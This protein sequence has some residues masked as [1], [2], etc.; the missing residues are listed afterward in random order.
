LGSLNVQGIRNKTGEITKGLEELNQDITIL[1]GTK[2]KGNGVEILG[3]Y[4]HFYS[5]VSKEKRAKRGTSIL[6]KK[7]YER[8]I[9][10]WEAI[11]ENTIKL[12]MNVFGKKLC[13]LGIYAISDDKNA[14]VK[15]DFSGK[16]NEVIV[17]I[18]H[19]REISIAGDFN[20]RTGGGDIYNNNNNNNNNNNLVAGPF[21]GEVIND[22]GDKLIDICEQ[23]SLKILNEY[24]KHKRIHQYAWHQDTQ[25]LRSIID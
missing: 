3:P 17:E 13:I 14:L 19:S 8:Y 7:R 20:S 6:V 12:Y 4:L 2:I 9:K 21:G 22:N 5:R 18:E 23:I 16:L 15:E 11:N 10:T 24:F 25:E 1:T